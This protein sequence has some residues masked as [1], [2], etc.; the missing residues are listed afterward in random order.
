LVLDAKKARQHVEAWR[1]FTAA[2]SNVPF[3]AIIRGRQHLSVGEIGPWRI[4]LGLGVSLATLA[5]DDLLSS[6]SLFESVR[7]AFR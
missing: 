5:F 3:L 2:T 7:I 1:A 4:A 6:E